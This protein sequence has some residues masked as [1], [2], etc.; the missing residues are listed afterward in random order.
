MQYNNRSFWNSI[1]P[2]TRHL[3]MIN[4]I[5]WLATLALRQAGIIDLDRWLGLH[6]WKGSEFNPAQL[7]TYMFMH[8]DLM[9]IFV[10]MFMLW[11]FGSLLERVL[12]AKRYI[13]YYIS[14]GLGAALV[15]ELVWQFSWQSILA[16][17]VSGPAGATV[18][19][20]INAIN[21]GHAAFSMDDFYN[22]LITIGASGAVFGVLL[23]FGMLF[24]NMTMYVIPFPFPIKAK[25][26]VLADGLIELFFGLSGTMS[27]VAHFAHLGGML[28]GIIIIL[29]WK[30]DGTLSRGNGLY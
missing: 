20:V 17:N 4:L 27:N 30:H 26:V 11:M 23:A 12:G 9:H 29:Y 8:A 14:C 1:M 24:P 22:S 3:L 6:F 18:T 15:Q 7:F 19:E 25:W 10:N 21:S 16:S 28:A 2:V 5:M 13:F